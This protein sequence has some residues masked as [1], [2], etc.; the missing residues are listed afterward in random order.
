ECP[1]VGGNL[2]AIETIVPPQK[3]LPLPA[4]I[5]LADITNPLCGEHSAARIFGPQKSATPEQVERLDT[6]LLH[7]GH[8]IQAQLHRD[9]RTIPGGGAAGGLAAGA[10]AFINATLQSGIETIIR[11]TRLEEA[12]VGADW[13]ITGEGSFDRQ[14]L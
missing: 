3:P 14:S 5:A 2:H 7:L 4:V 8:A 10:I 12:I 6:V 1:P 9:V 13:I 11:E